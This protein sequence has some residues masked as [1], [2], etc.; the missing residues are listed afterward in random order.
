MADYDYPNILGYITGGP[1]VRLGGVDLALAISPAPVRSGRPFHALLLAQNATDGPVDLRVTLNLPARDGR[2][3]KGRFVSVKEPV[4]IPLRPGEVGY[5][6]VPV[7]CQPDTAIGEGYKLGAALHIRPTNKANL[8]RSEGGGSPLDPA[9]LP[10]RQRA[11]LDKLHQLEFAVVKRF[12]LHDELEATFNVVQGVPQPAEAAAKGGWF[13][14]W[15]LAEA[16]S[17][18]LLLARYRAPL[19]DRI[20]PKI[21]KQLVLDPLRQTTEARF[22]AAGYPLKPLEALLIAKLL[23]V[24]VHMADPG[25][26]QFDFLGSQAFNVAVRFKHDLPPDVVLPHWFEGLLRAIAQDEQIITHPVAYL[27]ARLYDSLLQ[28]TIPYAFGM[29]RTIT[30]EDLGSDAEIE[31]YTENFVKLLN[32]PKG[33]DFAHSYLPLIMSGAIVFDRVIAPDEH[34]D[35]SLRGMSEVLAMRD[36]EWTEDNDLVFL[37]TKEL[38]NRSLRLFGFQI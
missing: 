9:S 18:A 38:V 27:C 8:V 12:G 33:M 15:N 36:A 4:N 37:M 25:D 16:A 10:D 34:L 26:D 32:E 21:K 20:F 1:L 24:V 7:M 2:K 5:L 31:Q 29:I 6:M 22:R 35:E 3:Q 28:D 11:M 23:A 30:G 19:E 17:N 13:S 14:L